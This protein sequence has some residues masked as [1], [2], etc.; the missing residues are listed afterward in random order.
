MATAMYD[1]AASGFF[2]KERTINLFPSS[3][4]PTQTQNVQVGDEAKKESDTQEQSPREFQSF[5]D[6]KVYEVVSEHTYFIIDWDDT[7]LSTS[8]LARRHINL[9]TVFIPQKESAELEALDT[10]V[11]SFL[12]KVIYLYGRVL[13]VTNA[14]QGW[15][16]LSAKKFLP[17]TYDLIFSPS[18]A[19]CCSLS[20]SS[21]GFHND[22]TETE[23]NPAFSVDYLE[24]E[25]TSSSHN[26]TS[27][28]TKNGKKKARI[29]SPMEV[30]TTSK[31]GNNQSMEADLADACCE[32][33]RVFS[34]R[35]LFEKDFPNDPS[36]WKRKAFQ[37]LL[38]S[39]ISSNFFIYRPMTSKSHSADMLLELDETRSQITQV[40][41]ISSKLERRNSSLSGIDL[42]DLVEIEGES[43]EIETEFHDN[44]SFFSFDFRPTPLNDLD[45]FVFD[46]S[47]HAN[48]NNETLG[49]G[50]ARKEEMKCT[51]CNIISIGDCFHDCESL[52]KVDLELKDT[53]KKTVKLI[54][55]PEIG[56]MIKQIEELEMYLDRIVK[57]KR[58]VDL[59]VDKSYL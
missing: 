37:K 53:F 32:K 44:D 30:D 10:A 47:N 29:S 50:D 58:D 33:I 2:H 51:A 7:L 23:F 3:I 22:S 35:Y 28:R 31:R 21:S 19:S 42:D 41:R 17:E 52:R 43:F 36:A 24:K 6:A 39:R 20:S 59:V 13:I 1:F 5:T 38:R 25:S 16:E 12:R 18:N 9:E 54:E 26:V 34:A 45:E 56:Q 57:V 14:Q 8:W 4:C 55:F 40:S 49:D 46:Y 15:V 11:C 27:V 48:E